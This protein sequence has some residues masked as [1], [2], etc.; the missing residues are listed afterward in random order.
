M[1]FVRISFD[2]NFKIEIKIIAKNMRLNQVEATKK[3][4]IK[5]KKI[6]LLFI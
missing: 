6:K 2:K 1:H 4:E 5:E 3:N